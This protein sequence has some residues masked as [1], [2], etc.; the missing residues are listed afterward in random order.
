M[1]NLFGKKILLF[2]PKGRGIY[3]SAIST[4][5]ERM[6][7]EVAVYDERPSTSTTSKIAV[8]LFKDFIQ[9]YLYLYFR[10]VVKK[11][12]EDD[13]DYVMVVRGE[14]FTPAI[15]RM[16]KDKYKKAIFILYLWDSLKKNN[17]ANIFQFFDRKFSFDP[18]DVKN[19]PELKLRPLFYLPV[20]REKS[21]IELKPIDLVF[22]G[23]LHTDRY[24]FIKSIISLLSR[25]HLTSYFY[26]YFPSKLL[27]LKKKLTDPAFRNCSINDFYYKMLPSE[28]VASYITNAKASLDIEGIEQTGLTMRTIEVLGAKRKLITT[29]KTIELYDF[30]D[31]RNIQIVDRKN[32]QIDITFI[33]SPYR[34]LSNQIYH[35]YSLTGWTEDLFFENNTGDYMR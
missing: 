11:H 20:F 17:I 2:I 22:I 26:L 7:A 32:P 1:T 14:G 31:S 13:F 21:A 18:M 35:K 8:R 19:F 5:L 33:N 23:T 30:Y 16:L 10:A 29:N 4:E 24:S 6:G 9:P 34:E 3:G 27:F 12:S 25:Y 15:V 28:Q